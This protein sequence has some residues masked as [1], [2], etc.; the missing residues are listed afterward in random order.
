VVEIVVFATWRTLP[1]RPVRDTATATHLADLLPLLAGKS[2][3]QL[4]EL[5]VVPTHVHVVLR[6]GAR[7][8]LPRAMQYLKGASA[9]L[10][11]GAAAPRTP[12]PIA[13][14]AGYDARSISRRTLPAIRSYLDHQATHHG[15]PLLA[16]RTFGHRATD[17]LKGALGNGTPQG[18]PL[19][20]PSGPASAGS[21]L[22]SA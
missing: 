21:G 18:A 1:E 11:N 6:F 3:A 14:A 15:L 17:A 8:D 7:V 4:C 2:G 20:G 9:R 13:W 12:N 16:R 5:A 10:V 22:E 19:S